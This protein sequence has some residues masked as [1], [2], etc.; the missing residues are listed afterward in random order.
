M[1]SAKEF[2]KEKF[3]EYPQTDADKL[4]VAMMA[5]YADELKN[6]STD[7]KKFKG[8]IFEKV[9]KIISLCKLEGQR[10]A[11]DI[12]HQTLNELSDMCRL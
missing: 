7:L 5:S 6:N 1:K 9:G 4:A 12:V 2:W 3:D 11:G 10:K 8:E